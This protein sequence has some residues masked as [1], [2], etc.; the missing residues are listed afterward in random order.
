MHLIS[1]KK[2]RRQEALNER[3]WLLLDGNFLVNMRWVHGFKVGLS[4]FLISL[5]IEWNPHTSQGTKRYSKV[6]AIARESQ[7]NEL[8]SLSLSV[9]HLSFSSPGCSSI[10]KRVSSRSLSI[11]LA[12]K[13]II[14]MKDSKGKPIKRLSLFPW[15]TKGSRTGFLLDLSFQS[16]A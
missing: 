4:L 8:H 12:Q 14:A 2:R 7:G 16:L 10:S 5:G 13:F 6:R 9:S 11:L 1:D 15:T 3:Y